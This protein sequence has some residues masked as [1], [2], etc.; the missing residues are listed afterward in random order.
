MTSVGERIRVRRLLRGWSVRY[1]A[2]RAGI[3]HATWSR[4]ECGLQGTGN[5]FMVADIATALECAPADLVGTGVPAPDRVTAAARAGVLE[6]RRALVDIDLSEPAAKAAPSIVELR[7]SVS[8]ADAM[9]RA[10]DYAGAARLLPDLLRDLHAETAGPDHLEALRLLCDATHAASTVLRSLGYP[11]D[12]WLGAERCRDAAE[13]AGDPLLKGHAAYA[14]SRAATACGS[15][16]RGQTIAERAVDEL[17]GQLG[18][19]GAA[20][21]LGSLHLV[22]ALASRCR[23][24]LDD[25]RDWL[26]EAAGLARR[27]GE[28]DTMGMFFG[29]TN[30]NI[31][32]MS[33]EVDDG[34]PAKV[35]EIAGSTDPAQ[36]PAGVRQVFYYADTAR[37]LAKLGGRDREA[38]RFLLTAER[39]APQ[40]VRTSAE[41]AATIRVLLDRSRRRAGGTELR[42]LHERMQV[43]TSLSG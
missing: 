35:V 24:R 19:T 15:Y 33:I 9:H 7:R 30:V 40:H 32:R 31:W 34:D 22:A 21:V 11:A 13:M 4:I 38:I 14:L 36:I 20:E 25:S 17:G 42:A 23:Q 43:V 39:I 18:R 16:Q 6:L 12:A 8:L 10:C 5:R 2:S 29:P 27:T 1:A 37:A 41:L 3:S 26:T 28:T